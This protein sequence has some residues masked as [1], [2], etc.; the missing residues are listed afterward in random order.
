[1]ILT[2]SQSFPQHHLGMT[3]KPQYE[4]VA[5]LPPARKLERYPSFSFALT[6]GK[7]VSVK[8]EDFSDA[9][10]RNIQL[11][12][13]AGST[14]A[15]AGNYTSSST[16]SSSSTTLRQNDWL[17]TTID[18]RL[19]YSVIYDENDDDEDGEDYRSETGTVFEPCDPVEEGLRSS[20]Q[21]SRSL[22]GEKRWNRIMRILRSLSR[23]FRRLRSGP[24]RKKA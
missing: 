6:N 5:V 10:S 11:N 2:C 1:M 22:R 18:T 13:P 16:A 12:I 19:T 7:G 3:E 21:S 20:Q 14:I 4:K 15:L 23:A 8:L 17:M 24:L 9:V